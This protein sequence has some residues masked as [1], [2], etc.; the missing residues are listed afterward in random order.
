MHKEMKEKRGDFSATG[1][2]DEQILTESLMQLIFDD[3]IMNFKFETDRASLAVDSAEQDQGNIIA[4][5]SFR[6]VCLA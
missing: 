5:F 6:M 4:Y 2:P 3:S 1:D